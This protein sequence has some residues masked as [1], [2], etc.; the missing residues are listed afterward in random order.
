MVWKETLKDT[1]YN[2]HTNELS[3]FN[4]GDK[5]YALKTIKHGWKKLNKTQLK[6]APIKGLEIFILLKCHATQSNLQVQCNSYH[7]TSNTLHRNWEE[8]TLNFIL[9]VVFSITDI[10]GGISLPDFKIYYKVIETKGDYYCI[11]TD[12]AS[13]GQNGKYRSKS[14]HSLQTEF[15]QVASNKW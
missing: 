10:V 4:W 15:C 9:K 7:H 2:S 12:S 5:I 3:K 8:I 13:L 6:V 11:K 1:I 14:T